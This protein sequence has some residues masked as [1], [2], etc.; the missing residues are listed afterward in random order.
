MFHLWLYTDDVVKTSSSPW[1]QHSLL[2]KLLAFKPPRVFHAVKIL[3]LTFLLSTPKIKFAYMLSV[4]S[5]F[6]V[7]FPCKCYCCFVRK[8]SGKDSPDSCFARSSSAWKDCN[9]Q[10][11]WILA[12]KSSS[13]T[14]HGAALHQ[15]PVSCKGQYVVTPA[16]EPTSVVVVLWW[17][18]I[19]LTRPLSKLSVTIVSASLMH[20][21]VI[22]SASADPLATVHVH[23]APV[24]DNKQWCGG[25]A[26]Q[27][28]RKC[29][30][31]L[32]PG[33]A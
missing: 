20:K 15:K 8:W 24:P 21:V 22:E 9:P 4:K 16:V 18:P 29:W 31:Q 17:A 28:S 27:P 1:I 30:H 2:R 33:S 13:H 3:S 26:W 10:A 14:M 32:L 12:T 5:I 19:L 25:S 11:Q 7:T 23:L 6:Y